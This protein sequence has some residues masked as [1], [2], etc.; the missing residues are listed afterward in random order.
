MKLALIGLPQCG[1]TAVFEAV[2]GVHERSVGHG[3]VG[4]PVASVR[5]PDERLEF[6]RAATQPKKVTPATVD[7]YDAGGL[8]AGTAAKSDPHALAAAREADGVAK[9]VRAF[10]NPSV[11]HPHGAVDP[12]RDLREIDAELLLIDLDQVERRIEKLEQSLHRPVKHDER[13]KKELAALVRCRA[14]LQQGGTVADVRFSEEEN[15]LLRG[16]CFLTQKPSVAV[17][18]VGETEM[19]GGAALEAVRAIAPDAVALCAEV[20]R[21]IGELEPEERPAFLR[22]MGISEPGGPRVIRTAYAALRA[23]TF[24]TTAHEELRA[25]TIPDGTEAVDAAGKIHTD[26][27]RGF[28]RAEVTAFEDLRSLGSFRETRARGKTRLEGKDYVVRDGD[29]ITFRFST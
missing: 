21:E 14:T 6:L 23:V 22:E 26:M 29:I 9:V 27:A 20:E 11:P 7:F 4:V 15:L 2:S 25:W 3:H 17:V 28:I 16:F 13:E 12:A 18:N 24:Y 19:D 1:K 5:V 10:E 8:F